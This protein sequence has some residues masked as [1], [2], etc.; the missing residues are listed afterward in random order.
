MNLVRQDIKIIDY[1][2]SIKGH[3]NVTLNQ[4]VFL[5]MKSRLNGWKTHMISMNISWKICIEYEN[6]R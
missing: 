3:G 2:E 1:Q 5:F 6:L 4:I